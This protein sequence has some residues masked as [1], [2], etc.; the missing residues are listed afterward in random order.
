M[1]HVVAK[2]IYGPLGKKIDGM[3]VRTPQTEAFHAMLRQLYSEKEAELVVQMPWGLSTLG[4]I[5]RIT[6]RDKR[7][8]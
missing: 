5:S 6:G 4:R 8:C 1:G 2:D 3:S 7:A